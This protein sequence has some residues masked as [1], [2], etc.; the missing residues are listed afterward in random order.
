[1]NVLLITLDSV[2]PDHLS[3]YGYDKISTP[4]IDKIANEGTKFHQ[5]I[6]T[7]PITLP[8]HTSILTGQEVYTHGVRGNGTYKFKGNFPTIASILKRYGYSTKAIVASFVL[9]SKF[10]LDKGFD[11][12]DDIFEQVKA[13]EWLGHQYK[14]F[15]RNAGEVSQRAIDYLN[16]VEGMYFMWLHYF[17]PHPPYDLPKK[18]LKN[19]DDYG[20]YGLYD[21]A[22]EY[23][24]EELGKV[25][26]KVDFSNTLVILASDHGEALGEN[27]VIAGGKIKKYVGHGECLY[28]EEILSTLIVRRPFGGHKIKD[29]YQMVALS[30]I[31]PTI[32]EYVRLGWNHKFDAKSLCPVIAGNPE[33]IHDHLYCETLVP[34]RNNISPFFCIRSN[35]WKVMKQD[36]KT[37]TEC[38]K[39]QRMLKD[40]D[41]Y[42]KMT[43]GANEPVTVNEDTKEKLKALGYM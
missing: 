34:L 39:T 9:D 19:N 14:S 31:T 20:A 10:G 33:L 28:E 4:N 22:I 7:T 26:K 30:D 40:I 21:S 43:K 27:E 3:C 35:D 8:S 41:K 13:G 24:D 12:Y 36:D 37:R 2:R 17:D 29:I 6:A 18:F 5:A 15:E 1:M 38:I 16:K 23:I 42:K 32:L 11:S 25:F